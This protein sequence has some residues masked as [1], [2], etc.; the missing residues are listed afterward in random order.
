MS[1]M[2]PR[3]TLLSYNEWWATVT[4]LYHYRYLRKKER[5]YRYNYFKKSSG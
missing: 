2:A 1:A 3:T 4:L 5:S